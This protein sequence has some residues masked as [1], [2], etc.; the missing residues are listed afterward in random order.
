MFSNPLKT[1]SSF[2]KL[3]SCYLQI[4]LRNQYFCSVVK[5]KGQGNSTKSMNEIY[6]KQKQFLKEDRSPDKNFVLQTGTG[7]FQG[8]K[9]CKRKLLSNELGSCNNSQ[10]SFCYRSLY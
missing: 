4:I 5:I 3:K 2:V 8:I 9:V 7:C 6:S 1:N 10:V